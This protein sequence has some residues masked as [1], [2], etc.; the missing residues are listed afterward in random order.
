[1]FKRLAAEDCVIPG[2]FVGLQLTNIFLVM[3]YIGIIEASPQPVEG[4][5][6]VADID[7]Q[8]SDE[9]ES[10]PDL[11]DFLAVYSSEQVNLCP[12]LKNP[13]PRIIAEPL[14]PFESIDM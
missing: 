12:L 1:V 13:F 6:V 11:Q 10:G 2:N 3:G 7:Q 14:L 4:V 9:P 8:A 5:D